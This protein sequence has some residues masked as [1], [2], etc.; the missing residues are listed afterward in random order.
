MNTKITTD[1]IRTREVTA[2]SELEKRLYRIFNQVVEGD[3]DLNHIRARLRGTFEVNL[4][5]IKRGR[6]DVGFGMASYYKSKVRGKTVYF[7]RP[8]MGVLKDERGGVGRHAMKKYIGS[9]MK[10]KMRHPFSPVYLFSAP[11]SPIVYAGSSKYWEKSYPKHNLRTPAHIDAVKTA[12][13]T[14]FKLEEVR[15]GIVQHAF[16]PALDKEDVKRF[17]ETRA[18]NRH[19]DFFFRRN[20]NFL[21][22]EGLILIIPINFR[23]IANLLLGRTSA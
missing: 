2:F 11:V 18:K 13:L 5:F 19:V 9:Y 22:D 6:K 15:D 8:A 3:L 20:P 17:E 7:V 16:S 21:R 4:I 14:H 10:F 23:N 12:A 1:F